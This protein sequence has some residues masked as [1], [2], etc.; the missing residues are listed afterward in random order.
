[1]HVFK[2][3]FPTFPSPILPS[4]LPQWFPDTHSLTIP[5]L[6]LLSGFRC[7]AP[8]SLQL[9]RQLRL[10][11]HFHTEH[12][13]QREGLLWAGTCLTCLFFWWWW[14]ASCACWFQLCPCIRASKGSQGCSWERFR[15][16]PTNSLVRNCTI[17][18]STSAGTIKPLSCGSFCSDENTANSHI[19]INSPFLTVLECREIHFTTIMFLI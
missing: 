10:L 17:Q 13:F 15:L 11:S 7:R 8:Y 9:T 12:S 19:L 4:H 18:N 1:M 5:I 2:A 6:Q 14:W 3:L 16:Q